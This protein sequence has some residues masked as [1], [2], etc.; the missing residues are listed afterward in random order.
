MSHDF[1]RTLLRLARQ[2]A[3]EN[4]V[5]IPNR[6]TALRSTICSRDQFFIEAHGIAGVYVSADCAYEAKARFISQLIDKR[7][8]DKSDREVSE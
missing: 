5:S 8:E 2:E 3:S 6:L 7:Q 1:C 4:G